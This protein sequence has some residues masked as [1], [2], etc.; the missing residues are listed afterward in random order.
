M[1]PEMHLILNFS[2]SPESVKEIK[3]D[4]RGQGLPVIVLTNKNSA[5]AEAERI[6]EL[7]IDGK[8]IKS[9]TP[10]KEIVGHICDV[11]E[12]RTGEQG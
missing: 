11:L 3:K 1:V 5:T 8:Y 4:E 2:I 10:L 9:S 7:G 6:E 12:K